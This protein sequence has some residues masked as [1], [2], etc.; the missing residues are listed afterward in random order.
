MVNLN[1]NEVV[2]LVGIM[3]SQ[4]ASLKLSKLKESTIPHIQ[5][6]KRPNQTCFNTS[7]EGTIPEESIAQFNKN[8]YGKYKEFKNQ[9]H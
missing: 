9:L 8:Q 2:N 3:R 6:E 4:K 7:R 5:Q 1:W